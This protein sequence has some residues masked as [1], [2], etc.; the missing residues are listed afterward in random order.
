MS[1]DPTEDRRA[2]ARQALKDLERARRR[3]EEAVAQAMADLDEAQAGSRPQPEI[4]AAK[5]RVK[6][7]AKQARAEADA[8]LQAIQAEIQRQLD[9]KDGQSSSTD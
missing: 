2:E 5:E 4:D 3:L 9:G 6:G 1:N 7:W 8:H